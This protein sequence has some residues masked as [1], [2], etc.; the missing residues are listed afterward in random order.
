MSTEK[1]DTA[2]EFCKSFDGS[3]FGLRLGEKVYPAVLTGL[4]T[5]GT[6]GIQY[7]TAPYGSTEGIKQTLSLKWEDRD[8]H[9][10]RDYPNLGAV[11]FGPTVAYLSVK[12]RRQWKKGYYASNISMTVPNE[13]LVK[14]E[15]PNIRLM[16]NNR[17]LVWQVYNRELFNPWYA[18]D[19]LNKGEGLGYPLSRHFGLYITDSCRDPVISYKHSGSAGVFQGGK[20]KLLANFRHLKELFSRETKTS[21]SIV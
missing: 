11:K 4:Q 13:A 20:F 17:D 7:F 9:L 16:T 1:A 6:V 3:W 21:I 19:C 15:I 5:K 18:L 2:E 8:K 12:P 14:K 10:V